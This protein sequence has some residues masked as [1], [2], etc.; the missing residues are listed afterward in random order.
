MIETLQDA[1]DRVKDLGIEYMVTGPVAMSAYATARTTMDIDLIIE[2]RGVDAGVFER[3]FIDDYYVNA[4]SIERARERQSMFNVFNLRT[5]VK[6]DF[7]IR[8]QNALEIEKFS[9]RRLS[10][11]GQNEFWVI[12]K[13]DLILSKLNWAKDSHSEMQFRDIRNLLESGADEDFIRRM[14]AKHGL[15]EVWNV[16][17]EWKIRIEK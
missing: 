12:N 13:E 4:V 11:I 10:K 16:F 14:I 8:K 7:I 1:V 17:D 6:V 15:T 9:R 2:I 5:G 3:K